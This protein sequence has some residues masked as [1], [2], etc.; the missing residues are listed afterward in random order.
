VTRPDRDDWHLEGANW[1]AKMGDCTRRKVGALIVGPDKRFWGMGYNG[2]YPGGPSCLKGDC[3]R[4]L[5]AQAEEPA[6]VFCPMEGIDGRYGD[7]THLCS[8]CR[9]EW[10][11]LCGNAWPCPD[12]VAPGSSYDTGAGAC[13]ASHAEANAVADAMQRSGGRLAGCVMYVNAEPCEGC[14]RHIRNTTSIECIIWKDGT[15]EGVVALP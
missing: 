9:F 1:L 7:G 15:H 4:G 3:P 6:R 2:S 5:H 8:D 12:A 14:I 11:C 13:I 10:D